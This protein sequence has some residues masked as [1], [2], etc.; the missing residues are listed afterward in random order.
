MAYSDIPE[1]FLTQVAKDKRV[2]DGELAALRLALQKIKSKDIAQHLNISEAAARKR[3][4]EVY[5]KFEIKGSGPGK[6]TY[7][8]RHLEASSN[9]L[10]TD[11]LQ[12]DQL[13]ADKPLATHPKSSSPAKTASKES[14]KSQVKSPVKKTLNAAPSVSWSTHYQWHDAPKLN[15]FQGRDRRLQELKDWILKPTHEQKLLAICGIGGIGKTYLARKLA[16]EIGDQFEQVIW[17]GLEPDHNPSDFFTSLWTAMQFGLTAHH[18]Q[19]NSLSLSHGQSNTPTPEAGSTHTR[20]KQL[21]EALSKQRYLIIIDGFE[22][23]FNTYPKDS[24]AKANTVGVP[25]FDASRC[26][27]ASEYKTGF[28]AFGDWLNHLQTT[29]QKHSSKGSCVILTSREKPKEMLGIETKHPATKLYK[30]GGLTNSEVE[31]LLNS[32]RLQGSP[33]DYRKLVSRYYGHPMALR[34]A[35]NTVQDIFSGKINDFLEQDIS[36]F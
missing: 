10:Q 11:R 5:K 23:V 8:R 33:A 6:L 18:P 24:E 31:K 30:L 16:E 7:L 34:L 32:F 15:L 12:A 3:L 35:A 13:Q 4:G 22:K 14:A 28:S 17:M 9:Q 36:V 26:Q 25:T 29:T 1:A 21:S 2:S 19:V 27:Q 20:L